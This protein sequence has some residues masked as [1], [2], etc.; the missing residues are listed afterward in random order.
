[1]LPIRC[2]IK[3]LSKT[4]IVEC[5]SLNE[6]GDYFV[7]AAE[8][9]GQTGE[10]TLTWR[11]FDSVACTLEGT[12][13]SPTY[14]AHKWPFCQYF[15]VR[16]VVNMTGFCECKRCHTR[17]ETLLKDEA[18]V[19]LFFYFYFFKLSSNPIKRPKPTMRLCV[20]QY[21]TAQI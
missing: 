20:S 3:S 7:T 6:D 4:D 13:L 5:L 10:Y 17:V 8:H 14:G 18:G 12:T 1:M 15:I 16:K 2:N 9:V 11:V 19:I 21:S